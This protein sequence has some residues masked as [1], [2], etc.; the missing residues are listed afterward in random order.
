VVP[1]RRD[2]C[3]EL[4]AVAEQQTRAGV[5][6]RLDGAVHSADVP[7]IGERLVVAVLLVPPVAS[8]SCDKHFSAGDYCLKRADKR[9]AAR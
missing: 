9:F 3:V 8:R 7:A 1:A 6:E 4:R 5:I 2:G